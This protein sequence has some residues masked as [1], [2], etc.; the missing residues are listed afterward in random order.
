MKRIEATILVEPTPKGRARMSVIPGP[1][2]TKGHA[3]AYTPAKTAKAEAQIIADIRHQIASETLFPYKT[4][5]RLYATFYR[6]K[7]KT[8]RKSELYPVTKPDVDNYGKLLM[9]ALNKFLY[10]NDSQIT[11]LTLKKRYCQPGQVPRI[12]LVVSEEDDLLEGMN[13]GG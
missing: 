4:A 3:R 12:I 6:T 11:T 10:A 7:P 13:G 9:D 8:S 2:G 1:P 5:L